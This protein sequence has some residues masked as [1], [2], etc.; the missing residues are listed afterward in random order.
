[1]SKSNEERWITKSVI[2]FVILAFGI[3]GTVIRS[4]VKISQIEEDYA[5]RVNIDTIQ[6]EAID[7][8]EDDI[9]RIKK[10]IGQILTA[11]NTMIQTAETNKDTILD[12]IGKIKNGN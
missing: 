8:N 5:R 9:I 1:M 6:T 2:P 3:C 12:A 11:Q 7:E 10:D 4:E